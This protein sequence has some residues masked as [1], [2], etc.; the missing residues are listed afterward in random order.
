MFPDRAKW[1]PQGRRRR[2]LVARGRPDLFPISV[3]VMAPCDLRWI[4]STQSR[5]LLKMQR[6]EPSIDLDF[7]NGFFK[8]GC[9]LNNI[10]FKTFQPS[11]MRRRHTVEMQR[12][13]LVAIL[14]ATSDLLK[15]FWGP[16][17]APGDSP[18]RGKRSVF[19]PSL[20]ARVAK[21]NVF[22]F[23]MDSVSPRPPTP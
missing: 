14:V 15:L 7:A 6:F 19:A 3:G 20:C 10:F 8:K 17:R 13:E 12:F 22:I 4:L 9:Q 5:S 21:Q 23:T 2:K 1:A 11:S 16:R 18:G